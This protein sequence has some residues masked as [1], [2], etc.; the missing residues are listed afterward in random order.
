[1]HDRVYTKNNKKK[2]VQFVHWGWQKLLNSTYF[3]FL[4]SYPS[5]Q[6]SNI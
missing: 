2:K 4:D 1:M 5:S 3:Q 6:F